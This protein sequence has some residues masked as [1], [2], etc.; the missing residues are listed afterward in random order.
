MTLTPELKAIIGQEKPK[1]ASSVR[2]EPVGGMGLTVV[3]RALRHMNPSAAH[4]YRLMDGQR[5]IQEIAAEQ[6][7]TYPQVPEDELFADT[8]K[9]IREF[10]YCS[11][12]GWRTVQD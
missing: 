5:T 9:S 11:M 7:R 10:Q 4:I 2:L 3:N 6:Q 1:A 8:L 12:A